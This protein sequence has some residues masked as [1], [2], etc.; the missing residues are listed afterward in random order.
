MVSFNRNPIRDEAKTK[1][2]KRQGGYDRLRSAGAGVRH[3]LSRTGTFER[4]EMYRKDEMKQGG[5]QKR[6]KWEMR[7]PGLV[8]IGGLKRKL[9]DVCRKV[10]KEYTVFIERV[11]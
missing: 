2:G 10:K 6:E 8:F 4:E 5:N 9:Y 7:S 1:R 3:T 11:F